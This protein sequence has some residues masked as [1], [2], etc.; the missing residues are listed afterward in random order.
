MNV[1]TTR[2][3][4]LEVD[5][6]TLITMPS[7]PLG[8]EGYTRFCLIQHD[9]AASFRW[10]QSIEKPSLAF[11]VVDTSEYFADY[12][13]E[14]SDADAAKLQL[15]DEKDALVLTILT[16]RDNGQDISANLAAPVI[17][18]SKNLMG[19]QIVLSDERYTTQHALI[20]TRAAKNIATKVA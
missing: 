5:D 10:L 6:G 7:G 19:A 11:V 1:E 14:I 20:R 8:F 4:V 17:V 9:A 2:F 3:G 18:N 16:I 15:E 12:E 13:I